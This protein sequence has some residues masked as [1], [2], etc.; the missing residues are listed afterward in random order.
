MLRGHVDPIPVW[1]DWTSS[2]REMSMTPWPP[3]WLPE[4]PRRPYTCLLRPC[5]AGRGNLF[6]NKVYTGYTRREGALR[7]KGTRPYGAPVAPRF[8]AV[9]FFRTSASDFS[10][11]ASG[12][13]RSCMAKSL[14]RAPMTSSDWC[15]PWTVAA[16]VRSIRSWDLVKIALPSVASSRG[17][18]RV[19]WPTPLTALA[20]DL[21]IASSKFL[22][23][24]GSI[25]GAPPAPIWGLAASS[26]E[27][28][29]TATKGS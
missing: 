7:S 18:P 25:L 2:G 19:T 27:A 13:N 12:A 22:P 3:V 24:G 21:V 15:V 14:D 8:W 9:K 1:P 28:Y 29:V 11:Y 17:V 20:A 4:M 16:L 6:L 5:P 10:R 26:A 23:D